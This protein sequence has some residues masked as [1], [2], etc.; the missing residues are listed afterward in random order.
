MRRQHR[1]DERPARPQRCPFECIREPNG[2]WRGKYLESD[3][4]DPLS[5]VRSRSTC[6][7]SRPIGWCRARGISTVHA[8]ATE[9]VTRVGLL[10]CDFAGLPR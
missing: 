5:W 10:R 9:D 1:P 4:L 8:V 7:G 3:V 6:P 2:N